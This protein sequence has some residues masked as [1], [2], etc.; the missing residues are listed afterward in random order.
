MEPVKH[1]LILNGPNLNL[2]TRRDSKHYGHRS[3][4]Q[5]IVDLQSQ[6]LD[7]QFTYRQ[8]NHEG[9]LIDW[10]QQAE[11]YQAI[12]LN[13]GGYTHTSVA[14]RDA[15]ELCLVPVIEVHLSDIT[16]REVWRQNSLLT[17]VCQTTI[18]GQDCYEKAVDHILSTAE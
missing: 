1:I 17:E 18:I 2:I 3:M 12:I 14:L 10:I 4:E 7:I 5:I 16:K 11:D 6:H 15:V 13:A 9:D 8:S